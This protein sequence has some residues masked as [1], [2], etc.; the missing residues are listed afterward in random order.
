[1]CLCIYVCESYQQ[2]HNSASGMLV[3]LLVLVLLAERLPLL[4][5]FSGHQLDQP[6]ALV[7]AVDS[8]L[9]SWATPALHADGSPTPSIRPP[10]PTKISVEKALQFNWMEGLT[11]MVME[12]K[13]EDNQHDDD[14]DDGG[15]GGGCGATQPK[16][17]GGRSKL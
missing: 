5:F 16:K 7:A 11:F 1:M 13:E 17:G 4:F 9:A 3:P 2:T 12:K 10:Q 6:L 15:G 14:D 8:I